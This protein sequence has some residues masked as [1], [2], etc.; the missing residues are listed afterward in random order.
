MAIRDD[1]KNT[2]LVNVRIRKYAEI[3]SEAN[4][5]IQQECGQIGSDRSENDENEKR[6]PKL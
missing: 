3:S 1:Q 4:P 6:G 5:E 2:P